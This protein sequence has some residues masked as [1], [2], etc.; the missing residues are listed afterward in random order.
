MGVAETDDCWLTANRSAYS[1]LST[2][3][4]EIKGFDPVEGMR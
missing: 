2:Y 3:G 1:E 4:I